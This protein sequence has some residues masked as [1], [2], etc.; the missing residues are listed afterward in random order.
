MPARV[1]NF[2]GSA[3]SSSQPSLDYLYKIDPTVANSSPGGVAPVP[4]API[5]EPPP[6]PGNG[7]PIV[8]PPVVAPPQVVI[9]QQPQQTPTTPTQ[10]FGSNWQSIAQQLLSRFSAAPK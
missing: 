3:G 7:V 10:T 6:A 2:S 4:G 5:A 1:G 8:W 9:G